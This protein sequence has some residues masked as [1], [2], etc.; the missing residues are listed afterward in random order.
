LKIL[1]D[2]SIL[3][4][5]IQVSSFGVPF[6][7]AQEILSKLKSDLGLKSLEG[8]SLHPFFCDI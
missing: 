1:I 3:G 6:R 8:H 4:E 7:C 5:I 2:V